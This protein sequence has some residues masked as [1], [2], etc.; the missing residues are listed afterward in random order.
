[1]W[2]YARADMGSHEQVVMGLLK[3]PNFNE[4]FKKIIKRYI[5]RWI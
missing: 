5:K 4:Q 1:M 3:K 2:V